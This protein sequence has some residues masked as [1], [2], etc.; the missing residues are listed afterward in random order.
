MK[1]NAKQYRPNGMQ[2]TRARDLRET[3]EVDELESAVSHFLA[4][5]E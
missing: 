1:L 3:A 4:H 5:Q 2:A